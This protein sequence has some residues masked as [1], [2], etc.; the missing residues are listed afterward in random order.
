MFCHLL[1]S[2]VVS[3]GKVCGIMSDRHMCVLATRERYNAIDTGFVLCMMCG[4]NILNNFDYLVNLRII[5]SKSF[6]L[7]G[8]NPHYDVE[9]ASLRFKMKH[10]QL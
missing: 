2:G 10:I 8:P 5:I 9:V 3:S 6:Q 1:V 4:D 7:H